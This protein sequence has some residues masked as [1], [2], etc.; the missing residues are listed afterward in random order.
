[1]NG[2]HRHGR[3]AGLGRVLAFAG[4]AV[5]LL[6]SL[7]ACTDLGTRDTGSAGSTSESV[8]S[9][10]TITEASVTTEAP[11]TT[12]AAAT[13]TSVAANPVSKASRDYARTLGGTSHKGEKLYFVIGASVRTEAQ[14]KTKL[15]PAKA[16]GDMQSNFI[17]QLSDN[18]AGMTPGYWVV[19]EAYDGY[20]SAEDLQFCRRP[21][22][23][24]YVKAA[25]VLTAD[26]IPVRPGG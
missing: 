17:V 18:F 22:P 4:V 1:M 16:V 14:A 23:S 19:F 13:T 5:L 11:T 20:P 6:L 25:T 12:E 21:F 3:S 10:P 7:T 8:T 26:P 9:G 24:A 15:E 2:E